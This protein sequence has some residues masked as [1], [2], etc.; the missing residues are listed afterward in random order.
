MVKEWSPDDS[1]HK[2][3]LLADTRWFWSKLPCGS[4]GIHRESKIE[5][6]SR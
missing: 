6:L 3:W 4:S 1:A 5:M 2:V